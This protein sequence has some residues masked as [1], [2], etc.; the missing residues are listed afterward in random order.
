MAWYWWVL[1]IILGL[2]TLVIVAVG[3]FLLLDRFR[4]EDEDLE[5]ERRSPDRDVKH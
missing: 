1:A 3:L 4:K 5:P 2:N